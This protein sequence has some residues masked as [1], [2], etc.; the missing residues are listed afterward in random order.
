MWYICQSS[1]KILSKR[2]IQKG[3]KPLVIKAVMEVMGEVPAADVLLCDQIA[4]SFF[5]DN[6]FASPACK[7]V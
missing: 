6:G 2:K 5:T 3:P 7:V 4:D 1:L